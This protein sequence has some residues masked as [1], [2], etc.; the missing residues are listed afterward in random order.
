[1]ILIAAACIFLSTGKAGAGERDREKLFGFAESL[2]VEGEYYRAITE[3]KRFKYLYPVDM[4]VEKS[5]FRIGECYSRA[6]RWLEAIDAFNAFI[7]RYPLSSS[8]EDALYLKGQAQ[9]ELKRYSDA[10]TTFD[11]LIRLSVRY[12]DRARFAQALSL[13]EQEEWQKARDVF[14]SLSRGSPLY[15]QADIY[16][17][18]IDGLESI[19]RKS[20][21]LAGT[22]AILPGAGHLYA[23][24]PRDALLSFLLNGAFI[25]AAVELFRNNNNVAGGV[26]TFF[27]LG[28]YSGNIYSAVN[29][30]HKY[31]KRM[32]DQYIGDL[33]QKSGISFHHDP[34][35]S[36]YVMYNMIF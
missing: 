29:S 31:N 32:R 30:A 20:P 25:W 28:W 6:A 23:E 13:L 16:A 2:F 8:Y 11:E 3:Y 24:R 26:V 1:L 14:A 35:G 33:K 36:Y 18:G 34:L 15:N 4:L 12:R 21:A 5:D 19:P 9:K 10:M 22:L 17:K 7:K 27:E